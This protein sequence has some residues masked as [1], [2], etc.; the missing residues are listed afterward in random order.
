[1]IGLGNDIVPI[2]RHARHRLLIQV[3]RVFVFS[4]RNARGRGSAHGK[5]VVGVVIHVVDVD[6]AIGVVVNVGMR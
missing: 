2:G 6:G 4:V 5:G 3:A 1:M